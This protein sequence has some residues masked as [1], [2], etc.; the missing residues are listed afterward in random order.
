VIGSGARIDVAGFVASTLN[1]PDADFLA[2]RMRFIETPNAGSIVNQGAINA[3]SGGNVYLVAPEITNSGIITSPRGEVI[4]AAGKSVELVNPGTPGIRVEVTAPDNQAINLGEIV[5]DSGRAGIYAGIISNRGVIRADTIAAGENGEILLR[6]TKNITL[7]PGSV[8]SASGAPGGVHDG[9]TV[10]IVA[11]DTLDMQRGSA[12]RVDGGIDGG[13]GGFLEL[14]GKQKIALNGEFTGRALKAGYKNGSLLLDPLNINIVADSS[15]LATVAVGP[16]FPGYVVVSPDGSRIYSGSFNVGF[17]TVID[18]A[19][20]AV[21]ATIPVAGA[22]AIA[23]KPDGTRVYAVDQT[24]PGVPGTLSVIDTATNT[25]IAIAATGYGSNHISMRPDGTKAYITNGNDSRLTVLNTADNTTVQVNIQSGP[26]GSAVT[27]N[28]AFV[29]ANNGASNSV[30]V[31][32]TATNSVVTTIGVGANPQWIV[33]RPDGARAYTANLSGNS[34]SVIDTNPASP[35]VNTVLATIGVGS[36][37]RHIVT[38]PDGSRLYV[39]N[40]TGN[41]ISV[42]DTAT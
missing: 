29:Y 13:N 33:V 17:V 30:S 14:S 15:V 16:N 42:I 40:G 7:E 24:G 18:T 9:G 32:N 34:V 12:V 11:D 35:T 41:S 31:V 28:G 26:S 27:P 3:A 20:N 19:T 5:A 4:L 10:R 23:I 36:Q 38:S 6:A 8:I 25:L 39:T 21:V 1:L 2:G 22:V 37:P